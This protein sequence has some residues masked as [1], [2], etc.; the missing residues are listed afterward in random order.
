MLGARERW[1]KITLSESHT[2]PFVRYTHTK[3]NRRVDTMPI[4]MDIH[5][6]E[7]V[8]AYVHVHIK[9]STYAKQQTGIVNGL[10]RRSGSEGKVHLHDFSDAV[11]HILCQTLCGFVLERSKTERL[12]DHFDRVSP[13]CV[14]WMG[15]TKAVT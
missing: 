10:E 11:L 14:H 4:H 2:R 8:R 3:Q 6:N 12:G 1:Q 7:Y 13:N 9:N 15:L 5:T